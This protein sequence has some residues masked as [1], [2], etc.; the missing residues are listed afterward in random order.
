MFE[1]LA[2]S[3]AAS[4]E[5]SSVIQLRTQAARALERESGPLHVVPF[6]L[7]L[8][9]IARRQAPPGLDCAINACEA[10]ANLDLA[11]SILVPRFRDGGA[12]ARSLKWPSTREAAIQTT[13]RILNALRKSRKCAGSGRWQTASLGVGAPDGARLRACKIAANPGDPKGPSRMIRPHGPLPPL[14]LGHPSV[15]ASASEASGCF[16]GGNPTV[17]DLKH[18]L[19]G[20]Q[21]RL[22]ESAKSENFPPRAGTVRVGDE[23]SLGGE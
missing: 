9:P 17:C 23:V 15:K 7:K 20:I 6:R 19:A 2:R 14:F 1:E 11:P 10:R 22:A 21:H 4:E 12:I 13:P 5:C 18:R 8:G 3:G 16:I